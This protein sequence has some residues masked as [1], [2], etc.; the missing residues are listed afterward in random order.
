MK[1]S[2]Y[3]ITLALALIVCLSFYGAKSWAGERVYQASGE[4]SAIDLKY[5]TVVVEVPVAGR[6]ATVGGPLSPGAVLE[7]AGKSA[8]LGSFKVGD[9]V[10]VKWQVTDKGHAILALKAK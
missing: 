5:D 8:D 3:I 1:R 10:I 2:G 7:Q 4:I 6:M 9:R